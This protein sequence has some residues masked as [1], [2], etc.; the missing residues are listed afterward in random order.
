MMVIPIK[1]HKEQVLTF[2]ICWAIYWTNN[3]SSTQTLTALKLYFVGR[4]QRR[5]L[6]HA[7][8]CALS[9]N[10][11][12]VFFWNNHIEN[13]NE[14]HPQHFPPEHR[15]QFTFAWSLWKRA[16]IIPDAIKYLHFYSYSIRKNGGRCTQ[17][18]LPPDVA[19]AGVSL[20]FVY[21]GLFSF[22]KCQK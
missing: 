5:A 10:L 13:V 3:F 11:L 9:L 16:F 20:R 14:A 8:A 7:R 17:E 1:S 19:I 2:L 21:T 22:Y 18:V 6:L 4:S 15:G 12:R